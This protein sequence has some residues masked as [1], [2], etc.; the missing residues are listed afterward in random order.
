M[1]N[2]PK[3]EVGMIHCFICGE[4][5]GLVMNTVLTEKYANEIKEMNGKVIDHEPCDKCKEIMKEGIFLISVKDGES[6]D[7]PYRTGK[8][9]ALKDEAVKQ[10]STPEMFEQV[11]KKRIAFVEDSIWEQLGLP[12]GGED[13]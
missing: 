8:V 11:S 7:N 4:P 5:K 6:G 2:E 13:E 9:C 10:F 1:R 3:L 12:T